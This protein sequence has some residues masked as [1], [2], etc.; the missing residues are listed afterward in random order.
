M[1]DL[2]I[3]DA[4]VLLQESITD[5]VKMPT[6]GLGNF[7]VRLGDILWYVITKEQLANKTYVDL[8]S[9]GVK[10]SLDEHIADKANPHN[11]TKTQVGLG[12]VDNTADIDKPVSNATKSAII[13]ATTDMATKAYVNQ[14]DNLKADKATTLSGYGIIDAYTKSEIDTDFSGIKTLYDKNVQAGAGANGWTDTLIAVS[15]NINQRQINDGLESIAQLIAIK[16]PR[17]GQRV[18]VKSYHAG[19][20]K[21][22]GTF[23]YNSTKSGI[24]DGVVNFGGWVRTSFERIT[25]SMVG[26]KIDGVTD[27][28]LALQRAIDY[29]AP[30]NIPVYLDSGTHLLDTLT[31]YDPTKLY[32]T[33]GFN[34]FYFLSL[35]SNT[36]IIGTKNSI[37]KVANNQLFKRFDYVGDIHSGNFETWAMP[38]TKGFQVFA[39]VDKDM[40]LENVTLDGFTV[41]MNGYNN[42]I[43]P[44][45]NFSNQSQCHAVYANKGN[46]IIVERITFKDAPGSQVICFNKE[47]ANAKVLFNKFIDC[48]FL[49]GTNTHLDDHSTVYIMGENSTVEDNRL[50]QSVQWTGK[51]GTPIEI[52]SKNGSVKR[53]YIEKYLSMGVIASILTDCDI[54]YKDNT[55]K[56]ISAMGLDCYCQNNHTFDLDVDSNN[57]EIINAPLINNHPA[58]YL[59][60]FVVMNYFDYSPGTANISLANNNVRSINSAGLSTGERIANA[61][62]HARL[63]DTFTLSN[64]KVSGFGA[65]INLG[66]QKSNAVIVLNGNK[67]T[68]CGLSDN[69]VTGNSVI[70]YANDGLDNYGNTP[71]KIDFANNTYTNCKYASY[72][73]LQKIVAQNILFPKKLNVMNDVTD[74]WFSTT[75]AAINMPDMSASYAFNYVCTTAVDTAK[76]L[77]D[78]GNLAKVQY[79]TI[80][81]YAQSEQTYQ[82]FTGSIYWN[83][84]SLKYSPTPP[85]SAEESPFGN[86][87]GDRLNV[88]NVVGYSQPTGYIYNLDSDGMNPAWRKFG[89]TA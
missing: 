30:L 32:A 57:V 76:K 2:R 27:D 72:L 5:D 67:F 37:L 16:N 3:V 8:S 26:C 7:S 45:N 6:G 38:G 78:S 75:I 24:N 41:D 65:I 22:G 39:Q 25:S 11:V 13:T 53:N 87:I 77:P 42:K 82:K 40:M 10:D 54:E 61:F 52:H 17:N 9:K 21:G 35:K 47:V 43:Q 49:D 68:D 28:T 62:I 71:A 29:A 74:K 89:L 12:N 36:Q 86:K 15:E 20:N 51:G 56:S 58:K 81:V 84:N 19:L 48:G 83:Y 63:A 55:G 66:I 4:P 31:F 46:N 60:E 14:K 44:L 80:K 64:N 79:G 33:R 50:I 73:S 18:Y 69:F 59:R 70:N 85:V 23:V 88:V 1:A 34:V